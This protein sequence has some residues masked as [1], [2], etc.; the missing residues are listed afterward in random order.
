MTRFAI[1]VDLVGGGELHLFTSGDEFYREAVALRDGWRDAGPD[2]F[3]AYVHE[4][5]H[6][7]LYMRDI[8]D[9]RVVAGGAG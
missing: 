2:Q 6:R 8:R 5:E 1:H 4:G 3:W 9:V 7:R